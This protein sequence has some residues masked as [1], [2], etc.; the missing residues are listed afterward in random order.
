[1]SQP[2][3]PKPA[4]PAPPR[5]PQPRTPDP[6]EAPPLGWGILGTGG[7]AGSMA[8][9]LRA[10]TRQ[11]LVAVASRSAK[12]GNAFAAEHDIPTAHVGTEQLLA[13]DEVDVV[14][15]ASPHSEHYRQAMDA[16]A[17]GKHLLVEKAFTQTAEQAVEIAQFAAASDVTVLEA[18]WPRFLPRFDVLRQLLETGALG[19]LQVVIA[20]HGQYFDPDPAHRLFAPELAG[21]ALLDLGVYPVSLASMVLGT[22]AAVHAF[23]SRAF[24]GVDGQVSLVLDAGAQHPGAQ[25]VLNTT[26]LAKTPTTAS[27]SGTVARVELP[28]PFYAPGVLTYIHRDGTT[29][30]TDPPTITD[31]GLAYEAAHL[32]QLVADGVRQSPLLPLQETVAIMRTLDTAAAQLG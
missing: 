10:H 15:I 2:P 5:L 13:D 6:T 30:Q 19:E 17:A 11:R 29:L 18:M 31:G 14:Y 22:P 28:G 20:D 25:A 24:T 9:A 1:M 3:T 4:P 26:L 21:G 16:I 12:R 27:I 32:A 23:G 7:I 8:R